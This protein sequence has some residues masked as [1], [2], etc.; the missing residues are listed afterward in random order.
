MEQ[1]IF[2]LMTTSDRFGSPL[3]GVYATYEEAKAERDEIQ[4][5]Y[6]LE[7]Y[8]LNIASTVYSFKLKEGV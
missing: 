3:L 5:E 1:E 6:G 8:E 2:I 7:D 4:E